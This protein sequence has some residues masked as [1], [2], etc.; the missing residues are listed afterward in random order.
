MKIMIIQKITLRQD[1][2]PSSRNSKRAP[3]PFNT[4]PKRPPLVKTMSA[5]AI[6]P[7][8][9]NI[10]MLSWYFYGQI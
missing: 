3:I 9:A 1:H 5:N 6:M 8:I 7:M 2:Q 4:Q 10:S